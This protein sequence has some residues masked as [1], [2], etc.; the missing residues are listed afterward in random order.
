[1][2]KY[3]YEKRD[4]MIGDSF[5]NKTCRIEDTVKV[6]EANDSLKKILFK[7]SLIQGRIAG[8]DKLYKY[9]FD[10]IKR[11]I[12]DEEIDDLENLA[13]SVFDEL[14][15]TA[16]IVQDNLKINNN[17]FV[18]NFNNNNIYVFDTEY[19]KVINGKYKLSNDLTKLIVLVEDDYENE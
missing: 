1:M 14:L 9:L 8:M 11:D 15:E 18:Y 12:T 5:I 16:K 2:K 13:K 3:I 10:K 6:I 17:Y 4:N 7:L 19:E